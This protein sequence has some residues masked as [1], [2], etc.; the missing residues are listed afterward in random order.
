VLPRLEAVKFFRLSRARRRPLRTAS[1]LLSLTELEA[2]LGVSRTEAV[3]TYTPEQ[4][5]KTERR[6]LRRR[7]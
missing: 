1:A 6:A 5:A 4:L 3:P 7:R 2:L